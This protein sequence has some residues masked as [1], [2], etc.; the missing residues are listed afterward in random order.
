MT[1]E[2]PKRGF[3]DWIEWIGNKLP[4]PVTLFV[5]GA[6]A[7]L[8]ASEVAARSG[9]SL[10]NPGS[11]ELE[12]VKSLLSVEGQ[13]WLWS[14]LVE[15]FT[16][17]PPLGVVL[18]GMIGIGLAEQSGLISALLK[19]I[20]LITPRSLVTPC[21]V[22]VGVM[23]SMA[24]DAGYIVLPPLACAVFA[25]MGRSPLVGMAAVFSGVG[26]GFSANL[27]V[28]GL[29]PLLQ[30]FTEQSARILLPDYQVD[31]RCNLYFMI[32]STWMITFAGW[33]TTKWFVEP[34]FSQAQ[35]ADQLE[36]MRA[37]EEVAATD[38]AA[39]E[40]DELTGAEWRGVLAAGVSLLVLGIWYLRMVFVDG[41]V[42]NGT[43]EPRPGWQVDVWV[44]VIVPLLFVTFLVPGLAYGI[45]AGT[46]KSDRDA[47]Q[48]M[49]KTMSQMGSYIVLAF[50]AAQ[51]IA[52][53][54]ESNLGTL[55]A[56]QGVRT[57][58]QM[59]LDLWM[60]VVGAVVLAGTLNLF[61]GSASAKWALISTVFV[62]VFAGVGVSPELTQAAY[63]VGDSVTNIVAPLNPYIV[64][65]LVFM[66]RYKPKA[67]IGS[68]ISLMIPY[69][70]V[71][72]LCWILL[73]LVWMWTGAP[74]GP[75]HE[76]LFIE[77]LAVE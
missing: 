55:V 66:Q 11:G 24:L 18:V 41:G 8:I 72:G 37:S 47:A 75:G 76:M 12:T 64:I 15:N 60:L 61:I 56:L 32:V 14:N 42:L 70:I 26:A 16:S 65:M 63:R 25:K 50:F 10:E 39:A 67:G 43:I 9:W 69:A 3:L 33:A 30:S 46:I 74:L 1:T 35:I 20:V 59:N 54:T 6:F 58:Q 23:S 49:S 71:F 53:F 73:L 17:F 45:F 27:V 57:L 22:F 77:P 31:V 48:M 44:T 52:W 68:L 29:D 5:I 40:S 13:R 62:P 19:G 21:V 4:D 28:T 34:R 38:Q 51:F 36:A 7:V 2:Q